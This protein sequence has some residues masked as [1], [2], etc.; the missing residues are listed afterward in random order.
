MPNVVRKYGIPFGWHPH[1][2]A[3]G[4][5]GWR[6]SRHSERRSCRGDR[7]ER[8]AHGAKRHRLR[9]SSSSAR[10]RCSRCEEFVGHT[11]KETFDE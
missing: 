6:F 9:E 3:Y 7:G 8:R 10:I 11:F 5:V 2:C 4:G 1:P